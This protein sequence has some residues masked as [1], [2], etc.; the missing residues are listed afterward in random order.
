[1]DLM[2]FSVAIP[3]GLPEMRKGVDRIQGRKKELGVREMGVT[4]LEDAFREGPHA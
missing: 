4:S 3:S 2:A 1:M